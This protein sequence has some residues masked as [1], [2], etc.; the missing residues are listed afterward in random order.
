MNKLCVARLLSLSLA[1]GLTVATLLAAGV[2]APSFARDTDIYSRSDFAQSALGVVEPNVLLVLDNSQSMLAPDGW[3]EYPGE[4]DPNVEYLWNDRNEDRYDVQ[5]IALDASTWDGARDAQ[6]VSQNPMGFFA[7]APCTPD[8]AG[9]A[10]TAEITE[11]DALLA[12]EDHCTTQGFRNWVRAWPRGTQVM[13]PGTADEYTDWA[14]RETLRNYDRRY[15]WWLPAGTDEHDK[16][17]ASL[18][19]NN[20]RG[21]DWMQEG[22]RALTNF[23]DPNSYSAGY[24]NNHNRC[25]GS[26]RSLQEAGVLSPRAFFTETEINDLKAGPGLGVYRNKRWLRWEPYGG[27]NT[28]NESDFP[29][30][31]AP[32]GVN[33]TTFNSSGWPRNDSSRGNLQHPLAD[34][35]MNNQRLPIRARPWGDTNSNNFKDSGETWEASQSA[36]WAPLRADGGGYQG[37]SRLDSIANVSNTSPA[38]NR[39]IYRWLEDTYPGFSASSTL[40]GWAHRPFWYAYQSNWSAL[41]TLPNGDKDLS[42][43]VAPWFY[44]DELWTKDV[45]LPGPTC[46]SIAGRNVV[47]TRTGANNGATYVAQNESVVEAYCEDSNNWT[48]FAQGSCQF[49]GGTQ[50]IWTTY[51]VWQWQ[52]RD[53][54]TNEQGVQY[55]YGGSCVMTS[56]LGV[57]GIDYSKVTT[58]PQ[59]QTNWVKASDEGAAC[60]ATNNTAQS[61]NTLDGASAGTNCRYNRYCNSKSVN[62]VKYPYYSRRQVRWETTHD[63]L[64]DDGD[65]QGLKR[66]SNS[67]NAGLGYVSSQT[68]SDAWETTFTNNAGYKMPINYQSQTATPQSVDVYSANYLNFRF[69]VKGPSGHPVGRMSRLGVAKKAI[70]Q[71]ISESAGVRFG[72]MVF[73]S[74]DNVGN[75][76]GG[77]VAFAVADMDADYPANTSISN[78]QALLTTI[79]NVTADSSTPLAETMYEA[80]LYFSGSTPL[81]GTGDGNHDARAILGDGNYRSPMSDNPTEADPALCQKNYSI[82]VTD[83]DP[84]F[85]G[86][87]NTEI[88]AL[89][90]T[91]SD[92]LKVAT[93]QSTDTVSVR[94]AV[95][96]PGESPWQQFAGYADATAPSPNP[97]LA[98]QRLQNVE[99]FSWLDE[100]TY[101]MNNADLIP[102][103][104]WPGIQNV[105]NFVIGFQGVNSEVLVKSATFAEDDSDFYTADSAESLKNAIQGALQGIRRW[106]PVRSAPAVGINA[107]DR[108]ETGQDV[109][110]AFFEPTTKRGWRGTLK[111]F[112]IHSESLAQVADD[113][114]LDSLMCSQ[115]DSV[116]QALDNDGSADVAVTECLLAREAGTGT[117]VGLQAYEVVTN[118]DGT[119]SEELVLRKDTH[120]GFVDDVQYADGGKGD[121]GGT[122]WQLIEDFLATP[123]NRKVY[124]RINTAVANLSNAANHLTA[125]NA[126][127]LATR[128]GL[129]ATQTSAV[130]KIA[131]GIDP[132]TDGLLDWPHGDILHS[133]P[134]VLHYDVGAATPSK[135]T[136][137]Y[138]SNDGLLRAVDTASGSELWSFMV[139]EAFCA[140]AAGPNTGCTAVS[141]GA[142]TRLEARYQ[143]PEG[144]HLILADGPMALYLDDVTNSGDNRPNGVVQSADGDEAILMFGL[145]RGGRAYYALDVSDRLQPKVKWKIDADS[146]GAFGLLGQTW[147]K[148]SLG[149]LR[150]YHDNARVHKPVAI[151][152]GGYDPVFDKTY[153]QL[154]DPA[155]VDTATYPRTAN[156]NQDA[157]MGIGVYVVDLRTG[158]LVRWFGPSTVAGV[159]NSFSTWDASN[160]AYGTDEGAMDSAIPSDLTALNMDLDT[161]GFFD[162]AYLGDL[163]GQV[164]RINFSGMDA[165]RWNVRHLA[166]L[167]GDQRLADADMTQV[168]LARAIYYPPA[169][170]KHKDYNMVLVGTGQQELPLLQET[171]DYLFMIKDV[172]KSIDP[173][174][175][176]IVDASGNL[177]AAW[178]FG[179][180]G[181][182]FQTA[183]TPSTDNVTSA[184]QTLLT[185]ANASIGNA[186]VAGWAAPLPK[187]EKATGSVQVFNWVATLPT[188]TPTATL[189]ACTPA[190]LGQLRV[191]DSK[192]GSPLVIGVDSNDDSQIDSYLYKTSIGPK[193]RGYVDSSALIFQDGEVRQLINADGLTTQSSMMN[194]LGIQL[195]YWYRELEN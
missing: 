173:A 171:Q 151:F 62:D 86:D 165:T 35:Y 140:Y 39:M 9:V 100:L 195:E 184:D 147:S 16:R 70:S 189:N 182:S 21:E 27:V 31:S 48:N 5:D 92:N 156:V 175:S 57:G 28:V 192:L 164:W 25:V 81:N 51:S 55:G 104:A 82:L 161:R 38:A 187:G 10:T 134:V 139:D 180:A 170:L 45:N 154:E 105:S 186:A 50:N 118:N 61:C 130:T 102:T 11:V 137:F 29:G 135:Q 99:R 168:D 106:T 133:S 191:F 138:L 178:V 43:F 157:S 162:A 1:S 142:Q 66:P 112:Q 44:Y 53:Y 152:A 30:G 6:G 127:A 116:K 67:W 121:A 167:T 47:N 7:D 12:D 194:G 84:E 60:R 14:D 83:G 129:D 93:N 185:A 32:V 115:P 109:Y 177:N 87:A 19:M 22:V 160:T 141:G 33:S 111:R 46:P 13:A 124:A 188:W 158:A 59:G 77:K 143:N 18:S 75:A 23:R 49:E 174:D 89:S 52:N 42:Q 113:S 34:I 94:G 63:C 24:G 58:G 76:E 117:Q 4:Y 145:R 37:T 95:G 120:D 169:A 17:L 119:T 85:D 131:R 110:M 103:A 73:N 150:G 107:G 153:E 56:G 79:A 181:N 41:P 91:R 146:G 176:S 88:A 125:T 20:W 128:F 136:L 96:S 65:N 114:E 26:R 98:I 193:A 144:E 64:Y 166:N 78:R 149:K 190:G 68:H 172:N 54:F 69:G 36:F 123:A 71:V 132:S 126:S 179:G 122:G 40:Q 74:A 90:Y 101:F 97:D 8:T 148:P 163:A 155:G 3:K 72:L 80:S 2:S 15:L 183:L 159:S 108:A